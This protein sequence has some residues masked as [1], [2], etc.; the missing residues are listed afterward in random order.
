MSTVKPSCKWYGPVKHRACK[1]KSPGSNSERFPRGVFHQYELNI[2]TSKYIVG[3]GR[4]SIGNDL[5]IS[6]FT[7]GPEKYNS[8]WYHLADDTSA[9]V[10]V[11]PKPTEQDA[12]IVDLQVC[13]MFFNP[14]DLH[15]RNKK[16]TVMCCELL[17][18]RKTTIAGL[19]ETS[20][21]RYIKQ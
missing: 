20:N 6:K 11:S 1:H 2:D 15:A 9:H 12:N 10:I 17:N 19:V 14:K 5:L 3:V 13:N 21:E 16:T 8:L 18:V 7:Q 4:D